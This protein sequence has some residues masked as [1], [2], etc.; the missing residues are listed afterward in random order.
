MYHLNHY[1]MP[2]IQDFYPL[3]PQSSVPYPYLEQQPVEQRQY[4][5]IE[6]DRLMNSANYNKNLIIDIGIINEHLRTSKNFRQQLQTAAQQSNHQ[7]VHDLINGLPIQNRAIVSYS[8]GGLSITLIPKKETN[9][10]CYLIVY[11]NWKESF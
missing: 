6:P 2:Y 4:P 11:L 7:E 1:F 8:P 9:N 3:Y 10:C 5:P